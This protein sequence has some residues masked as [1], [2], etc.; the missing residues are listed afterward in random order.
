MVCY[1]YSDDLFDS[2]LLSAYDEVDVV[3]WSMGVWMA[4][5]VLTAAGI[6]PATAI[7]VNGTL[8]PVDAERGIAPQIFQGT[9]DGL[10]EP[11]LMKFRRRMCGGASG[12]KLFME[13]APQRTLDSLRTELAAI[14]RMYAEA[15]GS[16]GAM[17]W[18]EAVV[19]DADAIFP[20]PAQQ[21][22]WSEA[23]VRQTPVSA[24]HYKEEIF[25]HY[26]EE[27]WTND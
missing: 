27:I 10:S 11:T 2:S 25:K 1:D 8:H 7:A 24:P 16:A 21:C 18:D 14:G 6:E 13:A 17:R 19:G 3:A 9:L 5:H 12:Y 4:A 20:T 23:G 26:L 22:A 15:D